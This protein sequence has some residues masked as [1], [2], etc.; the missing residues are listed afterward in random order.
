M[1]ER[2]DM[3]AKMIVAVDEVR[4]KYEAAAGIRKNLEAVTHVAY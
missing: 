4:L 2:Q 3:V 1:A